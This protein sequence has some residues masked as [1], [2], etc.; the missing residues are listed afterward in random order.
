MSEH[1]ATK[2]ELPEIL[3]PHLDAIVAL[4]RAYGVER[5]EVF[6]SVMTDR[7]DPARSDI[8]FLVKYPAGYT[9]GPFLTRYQELEEEL[10]RAVGRRVDLVMDSRSLRERFRYAI[11]PTRYLLYAN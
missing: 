10:S 4:A 7:F 11:M 6:G 1:I 8:D 2:A 3:R 9:F 5:L